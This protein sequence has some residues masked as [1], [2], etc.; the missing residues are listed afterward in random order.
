MTPFAAEGMA[1]TSGGIKRGLDEGDLGDVAVGAV[2]MAGE[3]FGSKSAPLSFTDV[4]DDIARE[5]GY[6]SYNELEPHLQK[7]VKDR[8]KVIAVSERRPQSPYF[9]RLDEID[10]EFEQGL[11]F[12]VTNRGKR[13]QGQ[14]VDDKFIRYQ[15]QELTARRSIQ[16][17]EAAI[18]FGIESDMTDPNETDANKRAL[19]RWYGLFDDARI[20]PEGMGGFSY[21]AYEKLVAEFEAFLTPAQ[22]EYVLRNTYIYEIPPEVLNAL[23]PRVRM[24]RR[25]SQEARDAYKRREER[26]RRTAK[27]Y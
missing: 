4:A 2:S 14:D 3:F 11:E 20:G 23:S 21:D 19:D 24:R 6:A 15:F 12:L 18:N 7:A 17:N 25:L 22:K 10:Q 1:E 26:R 13:Y 8:E 16:K 5:M 27:V 9:A